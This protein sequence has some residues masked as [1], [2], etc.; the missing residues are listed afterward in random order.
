MVNQDIR[1][2]LLQ[3]EPILM[4]DSLLEVSEREAETG[5]TL[6]AGNFFVDHDGFCCEAG[7]VEHIAQSA[8]VLMGWNARQRGEA[9][10]IGYIGEVKKCRFEFLP[11][12]GDTLHTH[13]RFLSEAMGVTLASAE[14]FVEDRLVVSCKLKISL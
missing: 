5:L 1:E 8:S 7:V 2:Y 6:N 10:A 12:V 13:I 9:A 14:T 4:V 3:R 11:K